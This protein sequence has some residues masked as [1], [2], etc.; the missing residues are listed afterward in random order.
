LTGLTFADLQRERDE[1]LATTV[2]DLKKF[3]PMFREGMKQNNIC[4]FGSEEKLKE[5]ATLFKTT[6]RAIE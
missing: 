2:E 1:V 5:N 3:A 4:V 6:V